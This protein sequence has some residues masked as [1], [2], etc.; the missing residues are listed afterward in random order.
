[1]YKLITIP[2]VHDIVSI[3]LVCSNNVMVYDNINREVLITMSCSAKANV[4]HGTEP[5]IREAVQGQN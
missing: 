5:G 1:M 3:S 4:A 2:L